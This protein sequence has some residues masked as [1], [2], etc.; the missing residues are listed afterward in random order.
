MRMIK[1]CG[2]LLLI[3]S[4]LLACAKQEENIENHFHLSLNGESNHWKVQHYEIK[5]TPK[6]FK[7]GDGKIIFK[8]NDNVKS[9]FYKIDVHA[10]IDETDT[11]V[12]TKSVSGESKLNKIETGSIKGDTYVNKEGNPVTFDEVSRVYMVIE[13]QDKQ[14]TKKETIDLKG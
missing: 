14:N 13:W 4:S 6:L 12:H 9:E 8:G 3:V 10:V 11:V 2:L 7:A 5:C 1:I